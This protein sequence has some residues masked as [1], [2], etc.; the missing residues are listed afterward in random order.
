VRV[1]DPGVAA[2]AT[3][4]GHDVRRVAREEDAALLERLS[5]RRARLPRLD[6]LDLDRHVLVAERRPHELDAPLG[7]GVLPH[8]RVPRSV[9]AERREHR[10]GTPRRR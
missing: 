6:A 2:E 5:R 4:R 1:G 7:G 10:Q 9:R 8:V 3:R